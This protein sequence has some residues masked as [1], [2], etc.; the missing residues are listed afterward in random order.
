[1][2]GYVLELWNAIKKTVSLDLNQLTQS[3][4]KILV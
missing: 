2:S 1:M 3:A 4:T